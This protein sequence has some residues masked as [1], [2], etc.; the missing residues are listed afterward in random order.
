[1][2]HDL[3]DCV[4]FALRDNSLRDTRFIKKS[5]V[6]GGLSRLHLT[7]GIV[8]RSM[9]LL[10][11]GHCVDP[12]HSFKLGSSSTVQPETIASIVSRSLI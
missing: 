11:F 7:H 10:L 12:Q 6:G 8:I 3:G 9:L 4:E 2:L 5:R 1:M